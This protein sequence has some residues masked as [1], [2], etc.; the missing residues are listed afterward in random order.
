VIFL[1]VMRRCD[2]VGVRGKIVELSGSFV[3]VVSASPAVVA[4]NSLL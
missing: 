3:P 4:H 1:A 2:T